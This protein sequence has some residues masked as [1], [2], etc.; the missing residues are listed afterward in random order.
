MPDL[1]DAP[2]DRIADMHLSVLSNP[3]I[4]VG[5]TGRSACGRLRARQHGLRP[6]VAS[7]WVCG[8]RLTRPRDEDGRRRARGRPVHQRV[9]ALR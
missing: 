4:A 1:V 5:S 3:L 9:I 6:F 7:I 2:F 8:R